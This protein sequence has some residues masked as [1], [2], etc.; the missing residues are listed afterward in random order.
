MWVAIG[1]A[2]TME[3]S[4]SYRRG[5]GRDRVISYLMK[6]LLGQMLWAT[7]LPVVAPSPPLDHSIV[8]SESVYLFC[9]QGISFTLSMLGERSNHKSFKTEGKRH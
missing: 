6:K 8:S 9:A 2:K 1:F 3:P 7:V 5:C 4:P